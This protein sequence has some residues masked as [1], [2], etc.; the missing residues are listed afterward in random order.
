MGMLTA[1][2]FLTAPNWKQSECSL[3]DDRIN[4]MCLTTQWDATQQ[5]NKWTVDTRYNTDEKPHTVG[6]CL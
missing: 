1:A 6:F 5:E 2:L 4:K 3:S